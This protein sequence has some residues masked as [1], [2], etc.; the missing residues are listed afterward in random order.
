MAKTPPTVGMLIIGNEILSG[1]TAEKNLGSLAGLLAQKG[2]RVSEARVV[3]DLP[4][5]IADALND[6]R[7]AHEYVFTSGGIGPTHDDITADAVA[8]AFGVQAVEIPEA[9]AALENLYKRRGIPF[10]AA[11]R[12]MARA[13]EGARILKSDYEGAPGFVIEN[14]FICAGVPGVFNLM[15]QAA[16]EE[17]PSF[18]RR[19]SLTMRADGPESEMAE[20]LAEVQQRFPQL[21]IGSYPGAD[22]EGYFC[23]MVF[24]GDD[25]DAVRA[26]AAE[27]EKFLDKQGIP[28]RT[29]R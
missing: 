9:A 7:A 22:D 5:A 27:F 28:H 17:L 29:I 3:R 1:R 20:P 26:A 11:R 6:L 14:V 12:R 18:Q 16:I 24:G 21:E 15:A 2:M 25:Q 23:H 8:Q 4:E 19:V 10:T 13:P